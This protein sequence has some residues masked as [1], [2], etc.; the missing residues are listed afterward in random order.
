MLDTTFAFFLIASIA[1]MLG[2]ETAAIVASLIA[3][4][5]LFAV[6]ACDPMFRIPDGMFS[7]VESTWEEPGRESVH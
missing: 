5:L 3:N 6:M 4:V 7:R 1:T 2:F